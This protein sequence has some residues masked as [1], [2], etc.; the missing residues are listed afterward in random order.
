MALTDIRLQHFRSYQD[1]SFDLDPKVNII[2]GPNASGKTNLLEAILVVAGHNSY[3]ARINELVSFNKA[4][5]RIDAHT[6]TGSRTIKIQP[7]ITSR[8]YEIDNLVYKR[9]TGRKKIPVS[10]FEPNHLL[11]LTG[12]PELRRSYIDDLA[13]Q[14]YPDFGLNLHKYKRALAQRNYLLKSPNAASQIFSWNIRLAELAG[15]VVAARLKLINE[16]DSRL[17]SVYQSLASSKDKVSLSYQSKID[18]N[19][20]ETNLLK[21]LESKLEAELA[22]GFTLY[23]P[24]RDDLTITINGNASGLSASRGE[25][26]TITL[27]LKILEAQTLESVAGVSPIMLLDDVF[28]ELDNGRR[29][30]L[31]SYLENY[32]T[33]ITT[34]DADVVLNHF[35]NSASIIPL[36]K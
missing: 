26:R 11:L 21:K 14:I 23:G 3:R 30:K 15:L 13:E 19:N 22:Q 20:Y 27:A 6:P 4:W 35:T 36:E 32:Q 25:A 12:S 33:F 7:E 2:V 9:L 34:T 5:A 8:S 31:T 29:Q 24:H 17:A 10:L 18:I 1:A 16:L 28:S